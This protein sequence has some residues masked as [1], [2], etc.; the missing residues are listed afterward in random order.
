MV[1][2]QGPD[3]SR[4]ARLRPM[5]DEVRGVLERHPQIAFGLVF[6]SAG[7]GEARAD[8]DLDVA[9][10]LMEGQHLTALDIGALV[11]EIEQATGRETDVVVLEGRLLGLEYRVF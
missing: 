4:H 8:S 3:P 1:A 5:E 9:V 11:S 2:R 6:G 7:R 10:G